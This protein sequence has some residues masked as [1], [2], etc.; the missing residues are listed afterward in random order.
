MLIL[1]G[2]NGDASEVDILKFVDITFKSLNEA[3]EKQDAVVL[4]HTVEFFAEAQTKPNQKKILFTYKN[5]GEQISGLIEVD[6]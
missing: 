6:I 4:R 2:V 5:Y 3:L 1:E